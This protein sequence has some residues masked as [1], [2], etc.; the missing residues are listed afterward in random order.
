MMRRDLLNIDAEQGFKNLEDNSVDIIVTD[1][2]YVKESWEEAYG[3]L[4]REGARVLKPSG[5]LI[6]YAGHNRLNHILA[7]MDRM[8]LEWYWI[9]AQKNAGAMCL[10]HSRNVIAAWKPVLIFQKPPIKN[11]NKIGLDM[12]T[13]GRRSK[14]YHAWQQSIHEALYLLRNFAREGD[15]VL[16]P[17]TGSGTV[18]LAAKALDLDY[19]GF[20]LNPET[21]STALGRLNQTS[22]T[23]EAWV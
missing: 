6:T 20:E 1:P 11:K 5:F 17:F 13:S 14:T 4:A 8:G 3:L 15:L 19:L 22:L 23:L 10:V 7:F 18:L 21:H 12:I 9:F 2:P 16:D